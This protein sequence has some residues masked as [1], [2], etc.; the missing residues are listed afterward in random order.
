MSGSREGALPLKLN[1][2]ATGFLT[3]TGLVPGEITKLQSQ[4]SM[5]GHYWPASETPFKWRFVGGPMMVRFKWYFDPL[6]PPQLKQ[7][8]NK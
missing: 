4:H 1:D 6:S 3:K 2:K 5:L 8:K 7:I